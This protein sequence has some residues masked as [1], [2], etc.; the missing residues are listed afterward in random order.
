MISISYE[1]AVLSSEFVSDAG[2]SVVLQ[3]SVTHTACW[4]FSRGMWLHLHRNPLRHHRPVEDRGKPPRGR[5]E[6]RQQGRALPE[7]CPTAEWSRR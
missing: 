4:V 1:G 5:L 6:T 2:L 3:V 7:P